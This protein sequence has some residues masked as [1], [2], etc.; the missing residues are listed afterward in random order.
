MTS[1]VLPHSI[2][3][4][5]ARPKTC[6]SCQKSFL[7]S[8]TDWHRLN[9]LF[10]L[11]AEVYR[12]PFPVS[13][14]CI[15]PAL[16]THTLCELSTAVPCLPGELPAH[17]LLQHCPWAAGSAKSPLSSSRSV[18]AQTRSC[19][20]ASPT[21]WHRPLGDPRFAH[22]NELLSICRLIF[23]RLYCQSRLTDR[24]SVNSRVGLTNAEWHRSA[25]RSE[26]LVWKSV[27]HMMWH[28]RASTA[29]G[30]Q[31]GCWARPGNLM[32]AFWKGR[33]LTGGR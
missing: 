10:P 14:L 5:L 17:K 3:S 19:R 33:S 11:G 9:V 12:N 30:P 23:A 7:Y 2:L 6:L 20:M 8:S 18:R 27:S 28:W 31:G 25:E 24:Q 1:P 13:Q 4:D 29:T 21:R 16:R 15:L 32:W 22:G 26:L